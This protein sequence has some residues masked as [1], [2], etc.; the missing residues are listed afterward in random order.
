M[1]YTMAVKGA[2]IKEFQDG[3]D[4]GGISFTLK[5]FEKNCFRQPGN[6]KKANFLAMNVCFKWMMTGEALKKYSSLKGEVAKKKE[7]KL[8]FWL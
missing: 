3:E 1:G 6:P 4:K 7:E 2:L 5:F 8:A